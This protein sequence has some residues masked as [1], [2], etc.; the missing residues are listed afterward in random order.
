MILPNLSLIKV[1]KSI[2]SGG[3]PPMIIKQNLMIKSKTSAS[4]N[5]ITSSQRN[6]NE[7]NINHEGVSLIVKIIILML[8]I[9]SF[10]IIV[11]QY[12]P[13]IIKYIFIKL[14]PLVYIVKGVQHPQVAKFIDLLSYLGQY[15]T[16]SIA[17]GP[18]GYNQQF[19]NM[20][21]VNLDDLISTKRFERLASDPRIQE[22]IISSKV[23]LNVQRVQDQLP[24]NIF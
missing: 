10:Y 3:Q 12:Y 9:I 2:I 22:Y 17:S 5:I 19:A 8:T 11:K 15:R 21:N 14:K 7:S 23:N 13:L 6:E 1:S 18:A 24:P 16:N 20:S 4:L